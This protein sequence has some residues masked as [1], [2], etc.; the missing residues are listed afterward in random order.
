VGFPP[1]DTGGIS[2]ITFGAEVSGEV[3]INRRAGRPAGV[4][5][6]RPPR[7]AIQYLDINTRPPTPN[8]PPATIRFQVTEAQLEERNLDRNELLLERYNDETGEWERLP[9]TVTGTEGSVV[10]FEAET[11]EFSAFTI[12]SLER[13]PTPEPGTE[14]PRT[15]PV[16]T[17][18][19]ETQPPETQPPETQPPGDQQSPPSNAEFGFPLTPVAVLTV[20]LTVAAVGVFIYRDIYT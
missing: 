13:Q 3:I 9:T 1:G 5:E 11:P 19:P 20:G 2:Q 15:E 6:V 16:S 7:V 10:L 18:P 17:E 8:G 4:P 14:P 12:T